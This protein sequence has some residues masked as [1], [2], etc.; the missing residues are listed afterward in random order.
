M[1]DLRRPASSAQVVPSTSFITVWDGFASETMMGNTASESTSLTNWDGNVS[2]P[3]RLSE[4][5]E[6]P[7]HQ[8]LPVEEAA[9]SLWW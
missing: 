5:A 6:E 2:A 4:V 9:E 7:T 8:G 3:V 1:S